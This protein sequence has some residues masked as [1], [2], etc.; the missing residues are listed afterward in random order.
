[1]TKNIF[2][3]IGG[4]FIVVLVQE[5]GLSHLTLF[6][7]SPDIVTI[8]IAFI[9]ISI[10]Q[11]TG[12]SFGFAAGILSGILSGNIGLNML[13][14]TIEGFIAGYFNIPEDSHATAKQK[15]KRLY[16]AIA[17]AGFCANAVL[18]TGNNP[19]GLPLT[20]RIFALGLL[21]TLFTLLLAVIIT[22]LFLRQSLAD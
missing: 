4:L 1:V 16:G 5:F 14:R 6:K 7:V 22:R 8:F 9:S 19:L 10:G 2:Y 15:I 17:T 11:K 21:E 18:E 3:F 20:Y 13:A 12:T